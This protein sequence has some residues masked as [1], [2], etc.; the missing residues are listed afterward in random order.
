MVRAKGLCTT[1]L[2]PK[3][4]VGNRLNNDLENLELWSR[5]QPSGQ[6][7]SDKVRAAIRLLQAHPE[8]LA[9]EGF[10]LL[11]LESQQATDL[12]LSEGFSVSDS[13]VGLIGYGR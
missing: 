1:H 6:R 10:S 11:T 5:M 12:L 9:T 8:L 4:A 7:V 3:F 13:I 2:K